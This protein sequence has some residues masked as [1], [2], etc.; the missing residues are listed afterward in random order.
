MEGAGDSSPRGA[1][2]GGNAKVA[3]GT[4]AGAPA[5]AGSA[6]VAVARDALGALARVTVSRG[7]ASVAVCLLGGTVV[8][9]VG[10]DGRERLLLSKEAELDGSKPLRGGVPLVFP[11][12]GAGPFKGMAS[13]GFARTATWAVAREPRTTASGLV[14]VA[15]SLQDN[16]ASLKLWPHPFRLEHVVRFGDDLLETEYVV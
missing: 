2:A 12:F 5:S 7:A 6:G 1:A 3:R 16:E 9:Y 8:S 4:G 10:G 15:F 11:Q 14:E 13:H